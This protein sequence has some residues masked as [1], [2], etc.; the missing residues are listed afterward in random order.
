MPT[1]LKCNFVFF[2]R[3]FMR[4]YYV[5]VVNWIVD[6]GC[7]VVGCYRVHWDQRLHHYWILRCPIF[8]RIE[9]GLCF[10][11]SFSMLNIHGWNPRCLQRRVQRRIRFSFFY[12]FCALGSHL[13]A[14]NSTLHKSSSLWSLS[15][16]SH[17]KR[18]ISSKSFLNASSSDLA[19][20]LNCWNVSY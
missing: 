17:N 12:A 4:Y 3:Y 13:R 9:L 11:F 19:S 7:K 5:F 1:D 14:F 2:G 15:Y 16:V 10:G 8:I 20:R 18:S 6:N